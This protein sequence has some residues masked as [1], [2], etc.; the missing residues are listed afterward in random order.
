MALAGDARSD[1][2]LPHLEKILSG[3]ESVEVRKELSLKMNQY[4]DGLGAVRIV[5]EMFRES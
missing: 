5:R 4:V 3:Y 2:F 1:D